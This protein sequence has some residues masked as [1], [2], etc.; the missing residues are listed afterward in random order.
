VQDLPR[1]R[2]RGDEL[3]I[4]DREVHQLLLTWQPG[5]GEE[6]VQHAGQFKEKARDAR[7]APATAEPVVKEESDGRI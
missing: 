5:A 3:T 2:Q 6:Q 1:L 4:T 7:L